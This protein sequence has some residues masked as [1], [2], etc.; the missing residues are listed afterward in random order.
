MDTTPI[1]WEN[2][3]RSGYFAYRKILNEHQSEVH[4]IPEFVVF[5]GSNDVVV[6]QERGN[7]EIIIEAGKAIPLKCG[8]RLG[9][10]E[11][12]LSFVQLGCRTNFIRVDQLGLKVEF[13]KSQTGAR[14][15][16]VCVQTAIDV[17]GDARLVVKIG[18]INS[19]GGIKV[20]LQSQP[21]LLSNDFVRF[22]VRWTELQIV[23]NETQEKRT[24]QKLLKT[25]KAASTTN[26]AASLMKIKQS[27]PLEIIQQPLMCINFSRFTVDFQRVFK[28][29]AKTMSS[30]T[31]SPE[32][33]QISVVIQ[34]LQVK[35]LTPD[36]TF[37]IVFHC[38]SDA[39]FF[40]LCVRTRGPLNADIVKVDLFDLNL[41]HIKGKSRS[42]QLTT[43]EEYVWRIIDLINRIL[44]AS[45]EVGGF[46][47]LLTEDE[48]H[49]GF[50]VKIE[51]S[52]DMGQED[53]T[54]YTPPKVDR[55][56][57]VDLARVSP[58]ALLVSFKRNPDTSRY[59]KA[60]N[61]RGAA[62]TNYFTRRLKFSIDKAELRFGRYENR[63][64]K[65]PPDRLVESL[66]AVYASR[67]K[68]KIVTL[69]TAAS[70]QDWK[71]LAARDNGDD[72]YVEGL[73]FSLLKS[74]RKSCVF[75][76]LYFYYCR[77]HLE[78]NWKSCW[79]VRK[80]CF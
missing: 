42:I 60:Q 15:G 31:A 45:S 7:E 28:D 19:V 52:N 54:R 22:R 71:F 70:F 67:M 36:S 59:K 46:S 76:S 64:L 32:R 51:D 18:D 77:R 73:S 68:F 11:I 47:L 23:L 44:T 62:L 41:A 29:P 53:Q 13:V 33:C 58:F 69:L 5:N 16:S 57:D 79:K 74:D 12:A 25:Q 2:K 35:D 43:S 26:S 8:S 78:S 9:G 3:K 14:V 63:G 48:D 1:L 65:G 6:I 61:V 20:G 38:S 80:S 40:D 27:G 50:I 10:L 66:G 37:P 34:S 75:D 4:V 21:G 72:E 49:G 30:R 56:Y 24:Q 55:L 39:N 17:L